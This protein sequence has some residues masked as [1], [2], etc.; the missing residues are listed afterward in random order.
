MQILIDQQKQITALQ[1]QVADLN[2]RLTQRTIDIKESGSI[3]EAA[4]KLNHVFTDAQAAAD[5]YLEHVRVQAA[6]ML[7]EAQANVAKVQEEARAERDR[8]LS[9][10]ESVKVNRPEE[11]TAEAPVEAPAPEKRRGLLS[12]KGRQA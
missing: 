7:E 9:T 8:I 2:A 4:M 1:E 10:A 6:Q 5:Q 3:A 12:R 11:K